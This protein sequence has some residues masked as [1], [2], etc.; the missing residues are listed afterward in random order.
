[1]PHFKDIAL[2]ALLALVVSLGTATADGG[3]P[4]SAMDRFHHATF[5]AV[6]N[7]LRS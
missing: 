2:G 5:V 6:P 1:M 7:K 3:S 4:K